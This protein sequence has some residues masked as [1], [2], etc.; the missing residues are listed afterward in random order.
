MWAQYF[1]CRAERGGVRAQEKRS[2]GFGQSVDGSSVRDPTQV[3]KH[4]LREDE[5]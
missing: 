1:V 3:F 5:P 2:S 4:S